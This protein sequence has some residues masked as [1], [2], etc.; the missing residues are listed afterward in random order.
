MWNEMTLIQE[1][2]SFHILYFIF[3]NFLHRSNISI[4][5]SARSARSIAMRVCLKS[6]MPLKMGL[7]AKCR[8][9]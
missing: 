1:L 4:S 6:G 5:S 2:V 8:R 7:A 9:V 3:I